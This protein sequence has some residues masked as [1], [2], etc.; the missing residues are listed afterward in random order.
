M[1]HDRMPVILD[2]PDAE[3]AWLSADV[4]LDRA[5]ELVRPFPDGQLEIYPA[6]PRVNNARHE[7]IELLTPLLGLQAALALCPV[8]LRRCF[9]TPAA[10]PG[11]G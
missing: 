5:L 9:A 3:A 4:D 2:G 10:A 1:V 11:A 6:S 7:V 8:S